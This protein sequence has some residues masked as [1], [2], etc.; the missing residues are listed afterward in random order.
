MGL[1]V[2]C[3]SCC[4]MTE[5]GTLENIF[6]KDATAQQIIEQLGENA[7]D[8]TYF[9]TGANSGVGYVTT[10]WLLK[11]GAT[12][13]IGCR[14]EKRAKKAMED[15][16][17]DC[18]SEL[19]DVSKLKL[20]I[21]DLSNLETIREV[22]AKLDELGIS[23]IDCLIN[24]AG[25]MSIPEYRETSQGYEMQYGVNHLGHFYLT[26]LLD[27]YLQKSDDKRVVI[28]SS[29]AQYFPPTLDDKC[30]Y[31][32]EK[33]KYHPEH[34]YGRTKICNILHAEVLE[35]NLGIA[36]YSLHPGWIPGTNLANSMELP[37]CCCCCSPQCV[38]T[39]MA[40]CVKWCFC[41][42]NVKSL[43]QSA[44][45]S[46]V[47][48]LQDQSKLTSGG[49]YQCCNL[50]SKRPDIPD[51]GQALWAY[52]CELVENFENQETEITG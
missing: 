19:E 3:R 10:K 33:E 48:A 45:T 6:S 35:A 40:M 16:I 34:V 5:D 50:A 46:L 47:C 44:S 31:P 25:I 52:S 27:P 13:V 39:C 15:L 4:P 37:A 30:I 12:V 14:S 29:I 42:Y 11:S 20:V 24:N 32:V 7:R 17:K 28:L 1:C 36:S 8:K 41:D 43:E 21:M 23:K 51:V 38:A 18:A 9:V 22:P 26:K 49:Y 2:C